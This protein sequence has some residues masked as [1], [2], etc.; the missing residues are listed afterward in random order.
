[1]R[2]A[3]ISGLLAFLLAGPSAAA[4]TLRADAALLQRDE[5]EELKR[6]V[7]V[8]TDEIADL[9]ERQGVPEELN[10]EGEYGLG[11]AAS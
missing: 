7:G 6:V 11:P 5:I 8:L 10:L 1:M 9:R 2:R 4:D 3:L